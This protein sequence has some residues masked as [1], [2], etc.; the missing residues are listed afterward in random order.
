MIVETDSLS[1]QHNREIV[2][3]LVIFHV[4]GSL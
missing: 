1:E 4:N 2:K 3:I